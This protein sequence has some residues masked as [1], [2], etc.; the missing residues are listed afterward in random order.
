MKKTIFTLALLSFFSWNSEAQDTTKA[1]K[2]GSEAYLLGGIQYVSF[3]NL[4]NS[5]RAAGIPQTRNTQLAS[6]FGFGFRFSAL[7][8]GLEA[9]FFTNVRE[10]ESLRGGVPTLY[11]STNS[12]QSK[13]LVF[14]PKVGI[15]YGYALYTHTAPSNASSFNNGLTVARNQVEVEWRAP[16]L[17]FGLTLK[18]KVGNSKI[19][20]LRGGYRFGL[21]EEA[22]EIKNSNLRGPADRGGT[23][24]LQFV[25]GGGN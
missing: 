12:L 3:E 17:D 21:S 23:A 4:D 16:M 5:L 15:G 18:R 22:W 10:N 6:G 13:K 14:A 24:Y 2:R 19:P 25:L 9:N 8:V 11:F 20:F 7:I 1:K